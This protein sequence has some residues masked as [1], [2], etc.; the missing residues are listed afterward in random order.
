MA[1]LNGNTRSDVRSVDEP[2]HMTRRQTASEQ[3]GARPNHHGS[4]SRPNPD[5][6][7]RLAE[8]AR[9]SATL[10]DRESCVTVVRAD[11]RPV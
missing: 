4:I 3:L 7:H 8:S 2:I 1:Y 5:D 6:E 10:A 11:H 9:Y